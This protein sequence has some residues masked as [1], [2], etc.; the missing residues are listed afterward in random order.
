MPPPSQPGTPSALHA[1]GRVSAR[2]P[3]PPA[4]GMPPLPDPGLCTRND[5]V[6]WTSRPPA[7]PGSA[8]ARQ[9]GCCPRVRMMPR[10]TS[11][12]VAVSA[13]AMC[14][15]YP[16]GA[17]ADHQPPCFSVTT[18]TPAPGPVAP[19]RPMLRLD[20]LNQTD[21]DAFVAIFDA[22]DEP[23]EVV[24]ELDLRGA[25][26]SP[27]HWLL[28]VTGAPPGAYSLQYSHPCLDFEPARWAF[29]IHEAAPPP[30]SIGR[31]V[32]EQRPICQDEPL[33][34]QTLRVDLDLE[35]GMEPYRPF[36]R[37]WLDTGS[38]RRAPVV[39]YDRF[40]WNL[41]VRC[42]EDRSWC[43]SECDED[44]GPFGRVGYCCADMLGPGDHVITL[45]SELVGGPAFASVSATLAVECK[46]CGA[47]M[48]LDSGPRVEPR[49]APS[50]AGCG[51][52][53]P[54][55]Q[56]G[57]AWSVVPILLL[58]GRRVRARPGAR[59]LQE[60]AARDRALTE[61]FRRAEHAP[62]E[63]VVSIGHVHAHVLRESRRQEPLG[64]AATHHRA[65]QE[66]ASGVL[67][68]LK[69]RVTPDRGGRGEP[70]QSRRIVPRGGFARASSHVLWPR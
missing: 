66:G 8:R 48:L 35:P 14:D 24:V 67:R 2:Q 13:A 62:Q 27:I 57:T 64:D 31:L 68:T 16:G 46:D 20:V 25:L 56:R 26:T 11:G 41:P 15:L 21:E 22:R 5:E 12:L 45:W 43:T 50:N 38:L 29:D 52:R 23:V 6:P 63:L 61:A 42:G 18:I 36:L 28:P 58:M 3:S 53:V 19:G 49:S 40:S 7:V 10:V 60:G 69:R 4:P 70:R 65:S 47:P 1:R 51:C 55:A 54:S 37:A 9:D 39:V 34:V 32:L 33:P 17:A 59:S 30:G 44:A